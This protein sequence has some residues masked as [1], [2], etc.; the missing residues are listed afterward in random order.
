MKY[1]SITPAHRK[2]D[3]EIGSG[4]GV[5]APNIFS[6]ENGLNFFLS[7]VEKLHQIKHNAKSFV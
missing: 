7:K 3:I 2:G 5:I 4:S 1:I 6:A